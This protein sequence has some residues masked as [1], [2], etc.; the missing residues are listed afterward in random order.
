MPY[1]TKLP[2]CI[3]HINHRRFPPEK[4]RPHLKTFFGLSMLD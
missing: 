1:N 3:T 2:E 4:T